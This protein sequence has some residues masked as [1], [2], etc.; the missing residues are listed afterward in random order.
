MENFGCCSSY[1]GDS[2]QNDGAGSEM[3]TE[4]VKELDK[5]PQVSIFD[6]INL[7]GLDSKSTGIKWDR[8]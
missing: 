2:N 3:D 5:L 8:K 6:L 4:P 7:L 1:I